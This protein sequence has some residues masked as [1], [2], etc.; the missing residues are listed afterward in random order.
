MCKLASQAYLGLQRLLQG[1]P[2]KSQDVLNQIFKNLLNAC[3][4]VLTKRTNKQTKVVMSGINTPN[5][6]CACLV[7]LNKNL[8]C[9]AL[10]PIV[11]E[12]MKN[13]LVF[14]RFWIN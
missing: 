10:E 4:H 9:F 3:L 1:P 7:K 12:I 8:L 2:F 14:P 11:T 6:L 5:S 13:K